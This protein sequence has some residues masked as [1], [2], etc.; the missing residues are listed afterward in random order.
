MQGRAVRFAAALGV[1]VLYFVAGKL[2]LAF[3]SVHANA[4]AVWPPAGIA[5]VAVLLLG[6]GIWPVVFAGAFFVNV[7]TAGRSASPPATRWRRSS[8]QRSSSAS[9]AASRP[10]IARRTSS[11]S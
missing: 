2:G 8:A 9:P 4:T 6:R 5:L 7:S 11:S 1:G 3:A 10:S